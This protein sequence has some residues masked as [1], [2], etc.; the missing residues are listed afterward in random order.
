MERAIG[1]EPTSSAW[2][3]KALPLDDT[4]IV[5]ELAPALGVE[6]SRSV[7][8]TN[9]PP[10]LAGTT[11]VGVGS[12]TPLGS[13]TGCWYSVHHSPT[14]NDQHGA[15]GRNQT[16]ARRIQA[17]ASL[18]DPQ[19]RSRRELH[20]RLLPYQGSG[21]LSDLHD[22]RTGADDRART[23]TYEL[24]RFACCHSHSTGTQWR[25][26]RDSNPRATP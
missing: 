16:D 8:E 3:A 12:R 24:T 26:R 19:R 1:F 15:A 21:L 20:S 6:P 2:K 10:R 5:K 4:R 18:S 11:W 13:F 25:R 22:R 14:H 9:P 23:D 7:L 17:G